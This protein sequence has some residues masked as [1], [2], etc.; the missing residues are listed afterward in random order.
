MIDR[1]DSRSLV[2]RRLWQPLAVAALNTEAE[3]GAAVL[4][5]RVLRESFGAGG[6][7]CRPLVPR[8]GLSESLVEPALDR[9]ARPR[10]AAALG[11]AAP[12]A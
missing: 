11:L 4:L 9:S 7:A 2:F 12:R 10:R 8:E 3:H 6:G 1:L 5:A